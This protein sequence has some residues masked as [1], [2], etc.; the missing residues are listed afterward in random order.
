MGPQKSRDCFMCTRRTNQAVCV[1]VCR[2]HDLES[3][4]G[5][6]GEGERGWVT[7]QA[8]W[9]GVGGRGLSPSLKPSVDLAASLECPLGGSSKDLDL[10]LSPGDDIAREG[11]AAAGGQVVHLPGG[12]L[13]VPDVEMG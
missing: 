13:A 5:V 1:C 2:G 8:G 9:A 3:F 4:L 7:A 6:G 12:Q 10:G 11:L